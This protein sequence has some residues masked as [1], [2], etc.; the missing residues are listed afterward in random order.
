MS[1]TIKTALITGGTKGIGYGVAEMLIK[2]GIKKVA[3]TG[4]NEETVKRGGCSIEPNKRRIC[5]GNCS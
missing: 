2:E 3:I 5:V 1:N 4:R